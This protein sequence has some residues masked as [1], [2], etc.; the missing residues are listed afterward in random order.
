[1][2][3]KINEIYWDQLKELIYKLGSDKAYRIR[4]GGLR[5][6][7]LPHG[8]D[9]WW[10]D[11]SGSGKYRLVIGRTNTNTRYGFDA[12]NIVSSW[13]LWQ[14]KNCCGICVS[15]A[16]E[17]NKIYRK[18]GLGAL[19]NKIRLHIAK[20]DGYGLMLCT[21]VLSNE[22]QQKI[23][24]ANGWDC[25]KQFKNPRTGN[26]IGIHTVDLTKMEF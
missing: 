9:C 15:T 6:E 13:E 25:V 23:L 17:V 21:D 14:M 20:L 2:L 4:N 19:L 26:D 11:K 12:F 22:P 24:T 1:M 3:D 8:D 7:H 5:I 16:V 18:S 10:S